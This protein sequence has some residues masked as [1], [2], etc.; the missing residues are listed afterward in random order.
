M[1]TAARRLAH[2]IMWFSQWHL[3]VP[4][5]IRHYNMGETSGSYELENV[6]KMDGTDDATL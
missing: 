1:Y 6:N 3:T 4:L 5:V 2:I